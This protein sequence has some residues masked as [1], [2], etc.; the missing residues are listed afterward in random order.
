MSINTIFDVAGSGMSAQSIRLN[1]VASNIA[2][3]LTAS[4][5]VNEVYRARHPVFQ[6]IQ[7]QAMAAG[8]QSADHDAAAG[9]RVV[10]IIESQAPLQPRYQPDHPMANADG[11]VYFPNVNV[12]EEM[13][14]MISA[15]RAFQ[16]NV[17]VLNAAKSMAQR[18]LNIGQ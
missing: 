3:A 4:S 14:D 15:S 6:A 2:N 7:A 13:T 10:A 18:V 5:S 1:T 11:Y 8:S 12:V 9:V 16:M 17:E